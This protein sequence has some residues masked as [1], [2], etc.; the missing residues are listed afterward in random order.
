ML[1]TRPLL[2]ALALAVLVVDTAAAATG[3]QYTARRLETLFKQPVFVTGPPGSSRMFV[4]ERTGRIRVVVRG[5]RTLKRPFLDMRRDVH[6]AIPNRESQDMRGLFSMALAPDYA[7][8][9]LFYVAYSGRDDMVHVDELRRSASDRNRAE[10][11]RRRVLT[12][13][14]A[15][16]YHHG[17]QLQFGPDRML[18]ISTGTANDQS[19]PQNPGD[20]HG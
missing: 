19:L 14:E 1:R 17:G 4:V 16:P 7:T 8:S 6:I 15:T 5:K 3:V 11:V 18:Y 12:V 2:L 9:G 13:G 10:P 20:L